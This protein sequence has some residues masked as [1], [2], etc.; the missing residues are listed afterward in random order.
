MNTREI[1]PVSAPIRGRIRPPGSKSIT[2]RALIVA[3]LAE[4][5]SA[6]SGVL[7]SDD[8]R[9][10]VDSLRRLGLDLRD[11]AQSDE[12]RLAGCA[13]RFPAKSAELSLQNSGT[14]IRF[15]TA[16]CALGDGHY[17]L[18]GNARMRERPIGPLVDAILAWGGD[19]RCESGN[20]CPPVVLDAQGLRGGKI[21]IA[22]NLSSQYL[23]ALLMAA[24]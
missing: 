12:V 18:D 7:D 21:E 4:G 2:N 23:S 15:L 14:S 6:L 24:P 10:M 17:R 13:G 5:N 19:A 11:D 9:V 8:T 22:G 3:A 1:T 16:L 20:G